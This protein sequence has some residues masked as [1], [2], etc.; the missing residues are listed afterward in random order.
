MG[1]FSNVER[2]TLNVGRNLADV[3]TAVTTVNRKHRKMFLSYLLQ[4]EPILIKFGTCF[5]G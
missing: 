1:L 5:P 3:E 2:Q 4:N